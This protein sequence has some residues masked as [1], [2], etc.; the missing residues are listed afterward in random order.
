[1][2][3][4]LLVGQPYLWWY[5]KRGLLAQNRIWIFYSS[6]DPPDCKSLKL[7][8]K[9]LPHVWLGLCS[10]CT[11]FL[12]AGFAFHTRLRFYWDQ[13]LAEMGQLLT[14]NLRFGSGPLLATTECCTPGCTNTFVKPES[15]LYLSY[16]SRKR[17]WKTKYFVSMCL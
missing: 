14:Q 15:S 2:I 5:F 3:R 12:F 13:Y 4:S 6:A 16:M 17:K 8:F 9:T 11:I 1:M 10:L 7:N